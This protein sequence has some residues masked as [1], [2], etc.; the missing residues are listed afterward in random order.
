MVPQRTAEGVGVIRELKYPAIDGLRFY[1]ALL[2][3]LVHFADAAG[4][5]IFSGR[6]PLNFGHHGVDLFFIISGFLITRMLLGQGAIDYSSFAM[7][8][9][10]R[11]YPAFLVAFVAA[12]FLWT[13]LNVFA[14][15]LGSIAGGLVF[16]NAIK[17]LNVTPYLW[18][19][20][21]LGYEFAFYLLAPFAVALQRRAPLVGMTIVSVGALTAFSFGAPRFL[22]LVAGAMIATARDDDLT[23]LARQIPLSAILIPYAAVLTWHDTMPT[24]YL[25]LYLVLLPVLM[26]LFVKVVFGLHWLSRIMASHPMRFLGT[27]SYSFYLWHVLCIAAAAHFVLGPTTLRAMWWP[28][29]LLALFLIAMALTIAVSALSYLLLEAPYFA[30]RREPIPAS[31]VSRS[32][33]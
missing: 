30:A 29:G 4:D 12:V 13:T 19:S 7:R 25:A 20:W 14:F 1:G 22:G 23:K 16:L 26:A 28:A 9:L 17:S 5:S 6:H 31:S 15:D 27:I 33:P 21:S 8:R 18:V 32:R 2:V 10:L 24:N 3:F 11:I